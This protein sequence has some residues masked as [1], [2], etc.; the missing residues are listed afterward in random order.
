MKNILFILFTLYHLASFCQSE[1]ENNYHYKTRDRV[2]KANILPIP[3]G[4]GSLSYEMGTGNR[5]SGEGGISFRHGRSSYLFNNPAARQTSIAFFAKMNL[6]FSGALEVPE[7]MNGFIY[8]KYAFHNVF[9]YYDNVLD[10]LNKNEIE[11]RTSTIGAGLGYQKKFN[12]RFIGGIY[13]GAGI[14]T[15]MNIQ[16]ISITDP[17]GI[18]ADIFSTSTYIFDLFG[19]VTVGYVF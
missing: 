19:G 14:N 18:T 2:I 4:G 13:A 8:V 11:L 5:R 3:F 1:G 9:Y 15:T 6:Y 12:E 10:E 16:I 17:P 7:G